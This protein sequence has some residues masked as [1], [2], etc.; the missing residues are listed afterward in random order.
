MIASPPPRTTDIPP[1]ASPGSQP[2]PTGKWASPAL[3]A[4]DGVAS[5]LPTTLGSTLLLYSLVAPEWLSAGVLAAV[6]GLV[7]T[8]ALTMRI[9]RPVFNAGRVFEAAT[10]AVMVQQTVLQFGRWGITDTSTTRLAVICCVLLVAGLTVGLLAL[11][12]AERFARFIPHPVFVA[13]SNSVTL[14][15]LL[16]QP[17]QLLQQMQ[18]S[19]HA[20][21]VALVAL[22][23]LGV[24]LAVRTWLPRWPAGACGLLTGTLLALG[25]AQ[26]GWAMP[27]LIA[28]LTWTL[29]FLQADFANL[30]HTGSALPL[31]LVMAKNGVILGVLIFLN[32]LVTGQMLSQVDDR[33]SNRPRDKVLQALAYALSGLSGS[34]PV[35]GSPSASM[36]AM[37]HAPRVDWE[38]TLGIA[39]LLVVAL[40]LS[41]AL[42]LLPTAA[43]IGLLL[44]D[45]WIMWDRPSVKQFWLWLRRHPLASHTREDLVVIA[46]VMAASLLANMVVGLLT[47]LLL[48]LLLHAH[49]NT[50]RPV[51]QVWTGRQVSSNCARTRADQQKL[52]EH[53]DALIVLELDT[54]QFFAS[55]SLLNTTVRDHLHGLPAH[56]GSTASR[57]PLVVVLDWSYVRNTDTSVAMVVARLHA[58]AREQG[59]RMLQAGTALHQGTVHDLLLQSLPAADIYPDLDHALEAAENQVI[60]HYSGTPTAL[61]DTTGTSGA[62]GDGD[63]E[64]LWAGAPLLHGLTKE[65]QQEVRSRMTL[66][67][68]AEGDVL[69]EAGAEADGVWL[70]LA[71]TASVRVKSARGDSDV[72]LAGMREGTT[73]GEVGFLDG[74]PRSA[75][76]R[77]ETAVQAAQLSRASFNRLAQSH[78]HIVQ[79]LLTNMALD[80]AAR[81]RNTHSKVV[82]RQQVR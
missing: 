19:P 4:L 13:F 30:F 27:M 16:T 17:Q 74:A 51:R 78:P 8:H 48:G 76:V 2:P 57:T 56:G 25:L 24:A 6:L 40:H 43:L 11:A 37:R 46:G 65:E 32:T 54:H 20:W 15:L 59:V 23:V 1:L 44:F 42:T 36:S 60:A 55:A 80:L 35:S 49:R 9:S 52:N 77:A 34:T 69:V 28:D 26:Q 47:G 71:G 10:L 67:S 39:A 7:I 72:R 70:I 33:A 12:R 31:M 73:V 14:T 68:L 82:A 18:A 81:F 41:G 38:R 62:A 5:A 66:H 61:P 63:T 21:P 58:Y 53:G 29:P 22:A 75:T 45:A 3:C 50:R 79:R 64:A